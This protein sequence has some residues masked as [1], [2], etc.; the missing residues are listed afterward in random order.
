MGADM[1][2]E[3][4]RALAAFTEE[5]TGM[6]AQL[7]GGQVVAAAEAISKGSGGG[8]DKAVAAEGT[9]R[10]GAVTG[11]VVTLS[12][13]SVHRTDRFRN[14]DREVL[15]A[16]SGAVAIRQPPG[17]FDLTVV[18]EPG[19]DQI[20]AAEA[21]ERLLSAVIRQGDISSQL[22][23]GGDYPIYASI[24]TPTP[25]ELQGWLQHGWTRGSGAAV[26]AVMTVAVQPHEAGPV[27]IVR[28]RRIHT[29]HLRTHVRETIE[30]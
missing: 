8:E 13:V 12:L 26:R 9:P 20:T 3:A 4:L 18:I 5:A 17:W 2:A 11:D 30:R 25:D 14:T 15:P 24:D 1:F 19:G 23:V 22:E 10:A 16:G 28:S 6:H 29:E 27:G 7:G 21:T